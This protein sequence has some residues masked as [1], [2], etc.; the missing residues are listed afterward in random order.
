MPP[1]RELIRKKGPRPTPSGAIRA[2]EAYDVA[3]F[4]RRVGWKRSALRSARANGLR[5]ILAGGRGYILGDDWL[6]Y[7]RQLADGA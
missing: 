1:E 4:L 5:V 7:L 6:S 2:G 3:E